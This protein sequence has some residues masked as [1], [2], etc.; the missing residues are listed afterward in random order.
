MDLMITDIQRPQ[1]IVD[2]Q[3]EELFAGKRFGWWER[4]SPPENIWIAS[5][6]LKLP[7]DGV[8][9]SELICPGD[10]RKKQYHSEAD[11]IVTD[12]LSD[13]RFRSR[14]TGGS[15]RSKPSR[16]KHV[17]RALYVR[18]D[19]DR[20]GW[21]LNELMPPDTHIVNELYLSVELHRV[22][23]CLDDAPISIPLRGYNVDPEDRHIFMNTMERLL[24]IA[25]T[26]RLS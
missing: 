22:D 9:T 12:I 5:R 10:G 18:T 14:W 24:T 6:R 13:D 26:A 23:D 4:T 11:V 19:T 16:L 8:I 21:L 7:L 2:A 3:I 25:R 20:R 17:K 1:T 15:P